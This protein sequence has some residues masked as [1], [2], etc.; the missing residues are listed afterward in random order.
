MFE[1]ITLNDQ[2]REGIKQSKSLQ[3]I[4]SQFRHVKMLYLQEQA[5]KKVVDGTTSINEMLRIFSAPKKRGAA[6][7]QQKK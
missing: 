2:L 1:I 5:L 3:E 6:K 7:P 4:K